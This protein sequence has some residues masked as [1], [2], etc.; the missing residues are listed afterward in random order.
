MKITG[1]QVFA[2]RETNFGVS[3]SNEEYTLNYSADGVNWTAW[4]ASTP[5]GENL[6]VC[7]GAKGMRY[8]LVG[9]NSDVFIQY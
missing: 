4:E 5:A 1:E 3:A 7:N 9:N 6:I 2:I 8:K